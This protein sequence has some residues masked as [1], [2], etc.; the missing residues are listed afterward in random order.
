MGIFDKM[1]STVTKKV[2]IDTAVNATVKT[3]GAV[4]DYNNKRESMG[5]KIIKVPNSSE[6]Y[7]GKNYQDVQ[8]ELLAYGF[9]NVA[10]LP[11]RDLIKGWLTK[12]GA[13]EKVSIKG[14]TEFKEKGKFPADANI[15]ITYHTFRESKH[16]TMQRA[17]PEIEGPPTVCC[18]TC[19]APITV[20]AKYCLECGSPTAS[21]PQ[22]VSNRH[23]EYTE[24][25]IKCPNCGDVLKPYEAFCHACGYELRSAKGMNPMSES[26]HRTEQ[27]GGQSMNRCSN[28]GV[29]MAEGA[30]FCQKCGAAT[31]GEPPNHESQR[32]QEYVGKILKCPNCGEVLKSF[33]GI[34][35][36]CGHEISSAQMSISLRAFVDGLQDCDR[37]IARSPIPPKKGFKT[38]SKRGKIWWIILNLFTLCIPLAIYLIFPLLGI[39]GGSSLLPEEKRKA[40]LIK[41]YAFP[42]DRA[43]VLEILLFIKTQLAFIASEKIDRTAVH[44][45]NIWGK[46]ADQVYQKAELIIKGDTIAASVH[47]DISLYWRKI[48]KSFGI[49]VTVA[50]AFIVALIVVMAVSGGP[51][52]LLSNPFKSISNPFVGTAK[53]FEWP[54]T[55]LSRM[56]PNPEA[57]K[58]EIH[59]ID[60]ESLWIEVHDFSI[61]KFER[62]INSC[63]EKGFSIEGVR[64]GNRYKAYADN[65]AYL[66]LSYMSLSSGSEMEIHL[67]AP[68]IGETFQWPDTTLG[69]LLS[70]PESYTGKIITSNDTY[71]SIEIYD[72][73]NS[74]FL[75]YIDICVEKDFTIESNKSDKSYEAYNDDGYLLQLAYK[76]PQTIKISLSAPE[77]MEEIQWPKSKI[78][79]QI[80]IPKSNIGKIL[81]ESETSFIIL[82]GNTSKEEYGEYV[83]ACLVGGFDVDYFRQDNYFR[84]ENSGGYVLQVG[85]E[86]FNVIR[87]SITNY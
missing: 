24:K 49:R 29:E 35:P 44:W 11:K 54:D 66:E 81:S 23:K 40:A 63:K 6:Y 75:S 45:A 31:N 32:Q 87:I 46:K 37:Q 2:L 79:N 56:L 1:A 84:G 72:A 52:G 15:V 38:W 62:Y 14:K 28:C 85:Y 27:M 25:V 59:D 30:K 69:Q 18:S 10:L 7:F 9:S 47:N 43:N 57:E 64:D 86:G 17:I 13:V 12:D 42:N 41:N 36:A 21:A 82:V 76:A 48:K 77:K 67:Y 83:N 5:S 70:A 26:T 22:G 61:S 39:W 58:G 80:L 16:K 60:A 50:L 33:E 65:G 3:V 19:G 73:S 20:N 68:K 34:C 8:A 78:A 55:E 4:A 53:I 71:L 74:Q 51:F